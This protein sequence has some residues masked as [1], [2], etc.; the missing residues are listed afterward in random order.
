[1]RNRLLYFWL[2][3]VVLGVT[4]CAEAEKPLARIAFLSDTH[5]NLRT[6]ATGLLYNSHFDRT[7]AEVNAANVDLVLITGDLTD[8]GLPEQFDLFKKKAAVLKAPLLYVPGNHDVGMVVVENGKEKR[9]ITPKRLE[10]FREKLGPG[11]FA[12]D[13]AGVHVIGLNSCLFDTGLEAE[14]DQ[15][16]FLERELAHPQSRP[17]LV[18]EHYPPFLKTPDEPIVG[19]W[20]VHP[21]QRKRLLE[22]FRQAQVTAVL[23][24]H[25]HYGFT[26]H[27]D[28]TLFLT[29]TAVAYGLPIPQQP[30]GWMLLTL[31]PKGEPQT[32][33]KSLE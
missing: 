32:E 7:I 31:P 12:C 28:G 15:W 24:G 30:A 9:S 6:N 19:T 8:N 4:G 13:K 33:F 27:L 21:E 5:V 2:W 10:L 29:T 17:T 18:L 20:N 25:T 23:S 3:L 16:K 26:N 11:W 1:M 14:A 22:L